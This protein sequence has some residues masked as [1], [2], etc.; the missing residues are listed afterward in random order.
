VASFV[1]SRSAQKSLTEII[2]QILEVLHMN[3]NHHDQIK[4]ELFCQIVKQI[5][6]KVARRQLITGV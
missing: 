2:V 5:C 3:I 1:G 4:D 6:G